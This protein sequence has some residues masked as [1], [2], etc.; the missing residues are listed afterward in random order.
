MKEIVVSKALFSKYKTISDA[1]KGAS[2][3]TTIVVKPGGY[4]ENIYIDKDINIISEG[5]KQSTVIEAFEKAICIDNGGKVFIKGI[6]VKRLGSEDNALIDCKFGALQ[7]QECD[8]YPGNGSG[9]AVKKQGIL[10]MHS[11]QITG[12]YTNAIYFGE[13]SQGT[14]ENCEIYRMKGETYPSIFIEKSSP[15]IKNCRIHS[16]PSNA[17]CIKNGGKPSIENCDLS[18]MQGSVIYISNSDPMIKK[19]NIH[20]GE[21]NGIYMEES[22][23]IIESCEVFN[24]KIG[25]VYIHRSKPTIRQCRVFDGKTNAITF[26]EQSAGLVEE[27]EIFNL[28]GETYPAIWIEDSQPVWKKC[29]VS[30][31]ADNAYNINNNSNPTI[32]NCEIYKAGNN[33]FKIIGAT[34]HI[35]RCKIYEGQ[36]SAFSIQE[37]SSPVVEECEIFDFKHQLVAVYAGNPTFRKCKLYDGQMNA[38]LFEKNGG[39]LFEDCELYQFS[40]EKYPVIFVNQGQ[41]TVRKCKMHNGT[42]NAIYLKN[43]SKMILDDCE[44]FQFQNESSPVIY[45]MQSYLK[46]TNCKIHEGNNNAVY[47]RSDSECILDNCE[48]GHFHN[49][50]RPMIW[51][52]ESRI[53]LTQCDLHNGK[54]G[55]VVVN[56]NSFAVIEDCKLTEFKQDCVRVSERSEAL[57]QR[58]QIYNALGGIGIVSESKLRV[59]DCGIYDCGGTALWLNNGQA[60]IEKIYIRNCKGNALNLKN[61]SSIMFYN[62]SISQFE[63]PMVYSEESQLDVKRSNFNFGESQIFLIE[64]ESEFWINQCEISQA[65]ESP[66]I[67][68]YSNVKGT[69]QNCNISEALIGI[70]VASESKVNLTDIKCFDIDKVAYQ[71]EDNSST[72][73]ENC[74]AYIEVSQQKIKSNGENKQEDK[75]EVEDVEKV[76]VQ[77][78]DI[79]IDA[80]MMELNRFVGM[81]S[82][83][84]QI[85]QLINYVEI[86]RYRKAA[87]LDSGDEIKPKHTVF[88]GNPET[89]KTTIARLLGKVY[90]ALGLLEKGHIVEVKREDLVGSYIGHSEEKTKGYIEEA[91]GGVLFIDEAYS[92]SVEDSGRDFGNQ[93]IDVLLAALE[94]HRGEFLCV[95]AG[96]EKEMERFIASNPGLKSR[97]VSYMKFEDYTPDELME[98]GNRLL[99]DK[100]YELTPEAQEYVYEQ[101]VGL[102]RKRDEHFGN[103]RMVREQVDKWKVLH[104]DR[105]RALPRSEWRKR[106]V[107]TTIHLE[108][109]EKVFQQKGEKKVAVPINEKLLQEQMDRL[110]DLIGLTKVKEEI[111]RLI[112]LVSYYQEE[113]KDISE[114]SMHISLIGNPG[115]GKTEVARI[116]A[117][118]YE[119]LGI[120]ERGDCIEVDRKGLV[121]KFQGGTEEKTANVLQQAMGGTLFIDEAYTLTNKGSNDVGHIAVELLLKQMEDRRGEFIVLVAGYED[122]MEEFL[123]SNKGLRRRFDYR[124]VFEDYTP[125]EMIRIAGYYM[126]K[127]QYHMSDEARNMLV[128]YFT[129]L[130]ENRDKTYGNAGL[131]RKIIEQAMKNLDYRIAT[132]PVEHRIEK[133]KYMIDVEDIQALLQQQEH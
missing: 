90:K 75:Q 17:I 9:V 124:L 32:E 94:N 132:L 57:L 133:Q 115:T 79:D 2:S 21:S 83:K 87:G 4:R 34:A 12:G 68:I 116:I 65:K 39:G 88:Y 74:K 27:C 107:L 76:K 72:V 28:L 33:A 64:K 19:C 52:N 127:K 71:I 24:F 108:D 6:Q 73:L 122:E 78:E 81:A 63:Y 117:K 101:F 14:I 3:G 31:T 61:N 95:V 15:N 130:Y 56:Q 111:Q 126:M 8:I 50:G 104:S 98:I 129:Y 114:L 77:E 26:K 82:V 22:Q 54:S 67:D 46:S 86:S 112:Q 60:T 131:A 55:A 43:D 105:I 97:F 42:S 51:A 37:D 5:D 20:D 110:N 29:K 109:V 121:D 128:D 47:A 53:T 113:G 80:I 48:I 106:E 35:Q 66:A 23:P 119:A 93:V 85:E 40:A 96:Y 30:Y 44:I 102:Y 120:L 125:E 38:V 25:M 99:E 91:M 59:I 49:D 18:H 118:V 84:E 36:K 62:S 58:N 41:P 10:S 100:Q 123:D 70:R 103:A 69:I 45:C 1:V 13:G 11:C 89:G 7:I 16:S 92:L